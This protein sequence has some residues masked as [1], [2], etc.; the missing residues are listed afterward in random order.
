MK[1]EKF[2]FSEEQIQYI[3]NNWGIESAHSM[4]KRFGC[5]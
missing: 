3:L 5:T 4:K 2:I 1:R